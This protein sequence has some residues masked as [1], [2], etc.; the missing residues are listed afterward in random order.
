MMMA[1]SRYRTGSS[2]FV[3]A[4]NFRYQSKCISSS[5][6]YVDSGFQ[7]PSVGHMSTVYYSRYYYD[8]ENI[9]RRLLS[10]Y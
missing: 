6:L 5:C 7:R 9:I 2:L 8:V 10:S 1:E 3:S 4:E